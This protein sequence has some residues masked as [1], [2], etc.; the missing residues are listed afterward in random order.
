MSDGLNSVQLIGNLCLDPELRF[1][2]SGMPVMN[3]R[4]ATNESYLDR[5]KVRQ[6][7]CEYHNIV[8]WGRRAEGLSKILTK[9]SSIFAAGSLRTNSYENREGQRVWKTEIVVNNVI[10]IRIKK[11]GEGGTQQDREL[12]E[13]GGR[14]EN[15][16]EP[17]EGDGGYDYGN[18][19]PEE[20]LQY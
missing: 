8:I 11:D 13:K 2:T 15:R 18:G 16:Q 4:L 6:N 9:G 7:R 3:L 1:T 10:L 20:D 14:S 17:D 5:D 12:R 19:A